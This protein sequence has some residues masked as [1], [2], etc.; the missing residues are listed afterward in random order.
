MVRFEI[1]EFVPGLKINMGVW[2]LNFGRG[3]FENCIQPFKKYKKRVQLIP[4]TISGIFQPINV[5]FYDLDVEIRPKLTPGAGTPRWAL[6]AIH[7]GWGNRYPAALQGG[8]TVR[9]RFS[10]D[11]ELLA[12]C[13]LWEEW[14][15]IECGW[16]KNVEKI[17]IS[18]FPDVHIVFWPS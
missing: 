1:W 12:A 18:G 9:G 17:C 15:Q 10:F 2:N 7:P 11:G 14:H 6:A 16:W 8:S 4:D 5:C 13:T 3:N